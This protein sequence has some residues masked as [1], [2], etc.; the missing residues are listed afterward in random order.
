MGLNQGCP[1]PNLGSAKLSGFA[2]FRQ[3]SVSFV[4]GLNGF[5]ISFWKNHGKK[6]IKGE[7]S[8]KNTE[9]KERKNGKIP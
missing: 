9:K 2:M 6:R 5:C 3:V 8:L 4:L 1:K 7:T